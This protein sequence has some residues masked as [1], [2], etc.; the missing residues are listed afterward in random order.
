MTYPNI[1]LRRMRRDAFSRALMRETD[2]LPSDL[3]LPVFV[4]EGRDVAEAVPSM[5]G[6]ERVSID[7]LL[8]VAEQAQRLGVP[9]L[10]LFPVTPAEAKSLDA[11]EAWNTDGLVQRTVR[12]LKRNFPNWA[13]S[14]TSRSIR[15]PRTARTASSTT[16]A[17]SSTTSP[18]KRWSSKPSRTPRPAPTSSRPRT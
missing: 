3:I 12:A 16:A 15:S 4:R 17:T 13:S 10:A 1:R 6:V 14:P 11:R 9:A 2:L 18:S 7:R 5:P 8:R